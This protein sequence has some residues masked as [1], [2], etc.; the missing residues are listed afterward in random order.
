M[1]EWH[2]FVTLAMYEP[3]IDALLQCLTQR[4]KYYRMIRCEN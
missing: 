1:P 3:L 4:P 2:A